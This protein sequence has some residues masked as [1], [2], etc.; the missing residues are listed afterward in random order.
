MKVYNDYDQVDILPVENVNRLE[1][2][3]SNWSSCVITCSCIMSLSEEALRITAEKIQFHFSR[4]E[5]FEE[6]KEQIKILL[7]KMEDQQ[8]VLICREYEH[9]KVESDTLKEYRGRK[10]YLWGKVLRR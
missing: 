10:N 6:N 7:L 9:Q 2:A 8:L 4:V 1:M 5:L 3:G